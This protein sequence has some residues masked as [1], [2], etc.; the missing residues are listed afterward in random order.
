MVATTIILPANQMFAL[1]T[2]ALIMLFEFCRIVFGYFLCKPPKE[3][4]KLEAERYE[5]QQEL[6]TIKSV[7]LEFVRHSLLSRKVIKIEKSIDDLKAAEA[8]RLSRAKGFFRILRA[9]AYIGYSALYVDVVV[10]Y[11]D[12]SILW[13]L[14]WFASTPTIALT[15]WAYVLLAGMASRHLFRSLAFAIIGKFD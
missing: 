11:F 7:N 13:P 1:Q 10:A 6:A 8:P 9:V 12:P 4:A 3:L 2:T 15:C 5:I 14:N